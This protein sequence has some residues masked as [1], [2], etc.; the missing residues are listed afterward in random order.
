MPA[1][2]NDT[3][4]IKRL[5]RQIAHD[6]AQPVKPSEKRVKLNTNFEDA[7]RQLSRPKPKK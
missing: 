6:Q 1:S 3:N 5:E 4:H 7:V 2:N